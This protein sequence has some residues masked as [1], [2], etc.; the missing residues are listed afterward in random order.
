MRRARHFLASVASREASIGCGWAEWLGSRAQP[1]IHRSRHDLFS[2]FLP[3]VF[4]PLKAV[5]CTRS[6]ARSLQETYILFRNAAF[7]EN[8]LADWAVQVGPVQTSSIKAAARLSAFTTV[9]WAG[10]EHLII[11][12]K[13]LCVLFEFDDV[14]SDCKS[15]S[16]ELHRRAAAA[17]A[18]MC[19][20]TA[21]EPPSDMPE[22]ASGVAYML[23]AL[24][25]E[26]QG[27]LCE[28]GLD[29]FFQGTMLERPEHAPSVSCHLAISKASGYQGTEQCLRLQRVFFFGAESGGEQWS[30]ALRVA[31]L[32]VVHTNDVAS[33]YKEI[34]NG[35]VLNSIIV[36]QAAGR[37]F[38]RAFLEVSDVV[39]C[40]SQHLACLVGR[41]TAQERLVLLWWVLGYARFEGVRA[42]IRNAQ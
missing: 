4:T 6:I 28:V 16:T 35:E 24:N 2:R 7:V 17:C 19:L 9:P 22:H 3:D 1:L 30:T 32:I 11:Y 23:S 42:D 21:M 12:A 8:M 38:E 40:L 26:A 34:A 39:R 41:L 27:L 36:R 31:C 33:Y 5:E 29:R 13:L 15:I 37:S 20:H 18:E 14:S 10:A 25:A